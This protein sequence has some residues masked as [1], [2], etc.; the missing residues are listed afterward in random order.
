MEKQIPIDYRRCGP[1]YVWVVGGDL[2]YTED[3]WSMKSGN[4]EKGE[5]LP[6][7]RS[8]RGRCDG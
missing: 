7:S 6:E 3:E 1:V 2:G 8:E 5:G 4:D